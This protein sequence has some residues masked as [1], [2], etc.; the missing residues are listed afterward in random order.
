VY[1]RAQGAAASATAAAARANV[2]RAMLGAEIMWLPAEA[3]SHKA[4]EYDDGSRASS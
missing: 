3:A 1:A 4:G 2:E